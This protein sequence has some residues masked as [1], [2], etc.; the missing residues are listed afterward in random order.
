MAGLY[1]HIPFCR[2]RCTYCDFH[3]STSFSSYRKKLIDT[4]VAEIVFRKTENEE[5]VETIYFGGGTPS[6]LSIDELNLI[7]ETIHQHYDLAEKVEITLE[8]NPEDINFRS[9]SDWQ[10]LGIN[11]L[12]VGFQSL[13]NEDLTWMNRGHKAEEARILVDLMLKSGIENISIDLIY[14]LPNLSLEKWNSWL[15]EVCSWPISHIS[16][17]CL[18][19]EKR[20][21]LSHLVKNKKLQLPDDELIAEQ[22]NALIEKLR[23]F[24]FEQYEVSNFARNGLYSK[25]NSSYWTG[26]KYLGFGPSA[27]S[28]NRKKRRW[29]VANNQ[30]YMKEM[31]KS[32]NWFDEE[33]LSEN[34]RW[35]ELFLIGLRT[36][37]GVSKEVIQQ[38]G[39]F[40]SKERINLINLLQEGLISENETHFHLNHHQLFRADGV[41]SSLFR[42]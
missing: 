1:F 39:G 23:E 5:A 8:A 34:E 35:N 27:H 3:F 36:K 32:E 19:V 21:A 28:Y 24:N 37:W 30:Q 41:A 16:A 7:F 33:Y 15:K 20:T 12:S 6:I 42:V 18:T 25:H 10:I 38:F 40:N 2:K 29:N 26:E 11:R 17:Y 13:D 31:G 9:L 22:Y 14:G 4:I